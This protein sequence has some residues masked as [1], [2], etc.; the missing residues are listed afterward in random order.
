MC[1][2]CVEDFVNIFSLCTLLHKE[3][4]FTKVYTTVGCTP[5]IMAII[6]TCFLLLG[7][8]V[9]LSMKPNQKHSGLQCFIWSRFWVGNVF[10]LRSTS[11]TKIIVL[12]VT[13]KTCLQQLYSLSYFGSSSTTEFIVLATTQTK[14]VA[15]VGL[16]MRLHNS[17]AYTSH[18]GHYL[19]SVT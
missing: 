18:Y 10:C 3:N 15:T 13:K 9:I 6:C 7:R 12:S 19:S 2:Y 8:L 5:P 14:H 16:Q 1:F 4:M 11:T 17:R